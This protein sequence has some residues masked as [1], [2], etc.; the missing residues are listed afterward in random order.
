MA[1]ARLF[2][3]LEG[4][5]LGWCMQG[6]IGAGADA[7]FLDFHERAGSQNPDKRDSGCAGQSQYA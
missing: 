5:P 1:R 2:A 3:A 6:I 7:N 4:K